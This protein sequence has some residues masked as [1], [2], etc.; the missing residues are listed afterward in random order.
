MARADGN[1]EFFIVIPLKIN[2]KS[3]YPRYLKMFNNPS[4]SSPAIPQSL[5]TLAT[6]YLVCL[7]NFNILRKRKY[8]FLK[9]KI[10]MKSV[11]TNSESRER[12]R[13]RAGFVSAV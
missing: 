4:Q 2:K 13:R 12:E 8:L 10:N 3:K 7:T 6:L 11:S 1:F 9:I 5:V